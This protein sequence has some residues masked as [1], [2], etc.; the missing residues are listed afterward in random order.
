M[1]GTA[2]FAGLTELQADGLACVV[3][4]EDHRP[5]AVPAVPVGVSAAGSQV[6]ACATGC[7]PVSVR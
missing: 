2:V 6:F 3:C 4:G 5:A 1:R 7:A